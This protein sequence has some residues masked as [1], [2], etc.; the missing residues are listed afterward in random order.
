[1]SGPEAVAATFLPGRLPKQIGKPLK[2]TEDRILYAEKA[3]NWCVTF[4]DVEEI[5]AVNI[6]W[7]AIRAMQRAVPGVGIDATTSVNS[8]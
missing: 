6:Y 4:V 2:R 8:G 5:D 1:M 3:E 7:A